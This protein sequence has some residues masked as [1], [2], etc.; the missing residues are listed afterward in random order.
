MVGGAVSG[1]E[2]AG[3]VLQMSMW[4]SA[5]MERIQPSVFGNRARLQGGILCGW[6]GT[7]FRGDCMWATT[8]PALPQG[9]EGSG[10][11]KVQGIYPAHFS[12]QGSLWGGQAGS[13]LV[14]QARGAL[15]LTHL[16]AAL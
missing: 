12:G 11:F 5:T 3:V 9:R 2:M 7:D 4:P 16:E 10:L 1:R 15:L 8:P 13:Q 6:D 14:Q